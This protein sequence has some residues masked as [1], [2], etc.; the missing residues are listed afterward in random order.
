MRGWLGIYGLHV[1]TDIRKQPR[2][3]LHKILMGHAKRR[4]C[5][6]RLGMVR[7]GSLQRISESDGRRRR[8]CGVRWTTVLRRR[9][10]RDCGFGRMGGTASCRQ[11][12]K[13]LGQ[14]GSDDHSFSH[15][16]ITHSRVLYAPQHS[17][18]SVTYLKPDL[19][20]GAT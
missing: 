3:A 10:L 11:D 8:G 20:H 9:A 5:R 15:S 14:K 17:C 16:W 1:V 2:S 7:R 19:P 13:G 4:E 12:E 18:L 6:L